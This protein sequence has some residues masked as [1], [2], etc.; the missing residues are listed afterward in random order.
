MTQQLYTLV[1]AAKHT[2]LAEHQIRKGINAG[3]IEAQKMGRDWFLTAA[4]VERLA[5]E[6]PLE[7]E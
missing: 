1:Q 4:E 5:K 7:K 6:H 3:E 2:S